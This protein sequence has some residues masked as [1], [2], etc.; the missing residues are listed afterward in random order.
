MLSLLTPQVLKQAMDFVQ[1]GRISDSL[2]AVLTDAQ[3]QFKNTVGPAIDKHPFAAVLIA[4]SAGALLVRYR[5]VL[6]G[7]L[8]DHLLPTLTPTLQG[9][10]VN[11][12]AA[13]TANAEAK[14][15]P[16]EADK[17]TQQQEQKPIS[18]P[19]PLRVAS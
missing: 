15:A 10:L 4:A 5:R 11:L 18:K 6:M 13:D 12:A 2:N 7:F 8:S 17:S 14:T 1:S 19:A 3:Q 16:V 9:L